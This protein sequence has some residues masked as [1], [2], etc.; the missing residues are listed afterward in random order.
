[1]SVTKYNLAGL[2]GIKRSWIK[3]ANIPT[4][5]HG[6]TVDYPGA[7]GMWMRDLLAG[8]NIKVAGGLGTTGVGLL[9]AGAPG[10][11][12]TT[13]ACSILQDFVRDLPNDMDSATKV[14][15]MKSDD[16]GLAIYP[17]YY[18]TY[19]GLVSRIKDTF[20]KHDQDVKDSLDGIYGRAKSDDLNVRLLVLDDLGK[21]YGTE[22]TN[23]TFD[24]VLRARYDAGLPT[25]ITTNVPLERWE[26]Q[27][28]TAMAS[29]ANEAFIHVPMTGTDR[30][31]A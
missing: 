10:I 31:K 11:G 8:E 27:Y 7:I 1:M 20:G 19:P 5:Y 14:L 3:R 12:K 9:L 6:N 2:P 24:E 15:G 4:R 17:A 18:L 16:F 21:E 30:R 26:G 13:L 23:S 25:I 22:F 29:F 28:G